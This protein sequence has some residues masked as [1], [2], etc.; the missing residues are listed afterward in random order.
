MS[1]G[2]LARRPLGSGAES[3]GR[4]RNPN[5]RQAGGIGETRPPF[6]LRAGP[7]KRDADASSAAAQNAG[8]SPWSGGGRPADDVTGDRAASRRRSRAAGAIARAEGSLASPTSPKQSSPA[9]RPKG[10][11]GSSELSAAGHPKC[12]SRSSLSNPGGLVQVQVTSMISRGVR[13]GSVSRECCHSA[14][15]SSRSGTPARSASSRHWPT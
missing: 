7:A 4:P 2:V 8:R 6:S 10:R 3:V 11:K 12:S 9:R 1:Q 13:L 15:S 5:A 14:L